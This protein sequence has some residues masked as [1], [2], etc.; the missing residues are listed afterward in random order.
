MAGLA[1]IGS[2]SAGL[3][4]NVGHFGELVNY[5]TVDG[6]TNDLSTFR[7]AHVRLAKE[8]I[9]RRQTIAVVIVCPANEWA[10]LRVIDIGAM[11][12]GQMITRESSDGR[13]A[14]EHGMAQRR[15]KKSI[16]A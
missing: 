16:V 13:N 1:T 5:G 2:H 11:P 7:S 9:F 14:L 3:E 15:K 4:I 8:F 10:D 6:P 12:S